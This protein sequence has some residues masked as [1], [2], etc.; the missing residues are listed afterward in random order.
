MALRKPLKKTP[1]QYFTKILVH[2]FI[3]EVFTVA[4]MEPRCGL[5]MEMGYF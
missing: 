5:Y 4:V 1:S 2:A 3:A